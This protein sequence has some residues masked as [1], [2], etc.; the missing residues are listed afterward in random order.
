MIRTIQFHY[1]QS[2]RIKTIALGRKLVVSELLLRNCWK[3]AGVIQQY[4]ENIR[5]EKKWR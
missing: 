4:I 2:P 3:S 5:Y 1:H